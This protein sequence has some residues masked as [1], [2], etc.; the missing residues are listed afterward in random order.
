MNRHLTN[1]YQE[2]TS[3]EAVG[4]L[5]ELNKF[6]TAAE[7]HRTARHT[8]AEGFEYAAA[9]QWRKAASLFESEEW[10]AELCWH[11]WERIMHLPRSLASTL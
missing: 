11:Q 6:S 4:I 9:M 1:R 8:E 2:I 7:L 3:A 10:L 5:A